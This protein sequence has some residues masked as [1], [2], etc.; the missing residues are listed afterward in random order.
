[1]TRI[2][3]LAAVDGYEARAVEKKPPLDRD[4]FI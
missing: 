2:T 3:D 1:M 4:A